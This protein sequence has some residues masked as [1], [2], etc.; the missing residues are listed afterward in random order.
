MFCTRPLFLFCRP[1]F[2]FEQSINTS[3]TR[4]TLSKI[5]SWSVVQCIKYIIVD[6]LWTY[7]VGYCSSFAPISG[8]PHLVFQVVFYRQPHTHTHSRGTI[9]YHCGHIKQDNHSEIGHCR[10][11][12]QPDNIK[13]LRDNNRRQG[14]SGSSGTLS[15]GFY[16]RRLNIPK[17][18]YKFNISRVKHH[19]SSVISDLFPLISS[20]L[21]LKLPPVTT[22]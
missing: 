2:S 6:W 3:F 11:D 17:A 1:P 4:V 13:K 5:K 18:L 16:F 10:A 22:I 20:N 14:Y 21:F 19:S 12:E 7:F 8:T 15:R 9:G